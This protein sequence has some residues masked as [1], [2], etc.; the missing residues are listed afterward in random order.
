MKIS[1]I[2][3]EAWRLLKGIKWP[4]W[5]VSITWLIGASILTLIAYLILTT[6]MLLFFKVVI[7]SALFLAAIFLIGPLFAGMQMI[8]IKKI[9]QE[10][11]SIK[12]GFRYFG[13]FFKLGLTI[14]LIGIICGLL[15]FLI[16]IIFLFLFNFVGVLLG[17]HNGSHSD[18][19]AIF[20]GFLLYMVAY[21][22]LIFVIP[23]IADKNM[24]IMDAL[25]KSVKA[26][27]PYWMK[28]FLVLIFLHLANMVV[29][30]MI[31]IPYVGVVIALLINIW[32]APYFFSVVA[33][34]YH[35]L[36]DRDEKYARPLLSTN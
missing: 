15:I 9:Q 5:V 28:I 14:L 2:L 31:N 6:K 35:R 23:L 30:L 25:A 32:L 36:I 26:A 21:A 1:Q 10:Q 33:V 34:L 8:P 13:S 29:S 20:I 18:N 4:F 16:N 11:V 17:H 12:S 7:L 19:V 24:G 27:R 22:L 3:L